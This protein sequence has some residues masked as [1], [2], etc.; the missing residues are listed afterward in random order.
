M[1]SLTVS[2]VAKRLRIQRDRVH[3]LLRSGAFP[4]TFRIP[5]GTYQAVR[6]PESEVEEFVSRQRME[7]S[8]APRERTTVVREV[9]F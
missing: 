5:G 8:V 9:G 3:S 6:I 7:S 1:K 4:N 2:E